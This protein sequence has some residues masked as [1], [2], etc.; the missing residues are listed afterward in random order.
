MVRNIGVHRSNDAEFIGVRGSGLLKQLA[1]L[2]SRLPVLLELEDRWID[3]AS[4]SLGSRC[5]AGHFL[6][7]VFFHRWL[8][9]PGIDVRRP[10]VS[11]DMDKV[12]G[13][14]REMRL[15]GEQRVRRGFPGQQFADEPW[16][17]ESPEPHAAP[18][19]QLP[20]RPAHIQRGVVRRLHNYVP[21]RF[22]KNIN[23]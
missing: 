13:L 21:L 5:A 19:Q 12:F 22:P 17:G 14:G 7:S 16:Q 8:G 18:M 10:A 9:I 2:E 20:A 6:A 11:K 1:D 15:L 4:R 3:I 23:R